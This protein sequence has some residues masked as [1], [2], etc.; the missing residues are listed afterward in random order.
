MPGSGSA[1][2]APLRK[3]RNF[4]STAEESIVTDQPS[5][6]AFLGGG[7][8]ALLLGRS[9]PAQAASAHGAIGFP[10][11]GDVRVQGDLARR[12]QQNMARLENDI[13]RVPRVFDN[14]NA[15]SWP[16]DFE[17]RALLAI[18]LLARSTAQDPDFLKD[19]LPAYKARLNR[20]GY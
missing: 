19:M 14:T 1:G 20:Q 9:H 12:T 13:Y 7:A 11:L 10:A 17:G 16:G 2:I 5:R 6:R 15:R 18:T 3:Q 8:A 4:I